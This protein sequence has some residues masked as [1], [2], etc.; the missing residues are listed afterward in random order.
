MKKL[1]ALFLLLYAGFYLQAQTFSWDIKFFDELKRESVPIS[2]IIRMQN[3]D[4]FS[5]V[6]TPAE[7]CFAYVVCYDSARRIIVLHEGQI[8]SRN[9]IF[10]GPFAIEDP[11][12]TEILYVVMSLERQTKLENLIQ[13][14]KKNPNSRQHANN[15]Y[16]EVVRLQ[17]TVSSLGE[18]PSVFIPSGG[19][20]R[21]GS[22]DFATRFSEK[23]MYVRT[24]TIRH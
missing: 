17:N 15:L 24:I 18:P 1:A 14:H 19:T 2:Q 7:D 11:A 20:T 22:E 6:I 10:L 12:G 21:G 23:N 13:T 4:E 8:K 3:G 5:L 9:E 16:R